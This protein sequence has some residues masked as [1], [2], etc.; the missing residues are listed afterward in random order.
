MGSL[1][2]K[3]EVAMQAAKNSQ[4]LRYL[5]KKTRNFEKLIDKV[6]FYMYNVGL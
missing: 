1:F 5:C 2:D 3:A 6:T 4:H